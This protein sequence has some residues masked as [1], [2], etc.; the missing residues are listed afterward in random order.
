MRPR[1]RR[2]LE[3]A[4]EMARQGRHSEALSCGE[5]AIFLAAD[6]DEADEIADW[7]QDHAA[8]FNPDE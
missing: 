5:A 2:M 6:Q 3:R 8:C 4:A 7:L 1:I